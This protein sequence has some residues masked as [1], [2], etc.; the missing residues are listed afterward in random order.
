VDT[1]EDRGET[2]RLREDLVK[3]EE[4]GVILNSQ[5]RSRMKERTKQEDG[6]IN[7][8]TTMVGEQLQIKYHH[9]QDLITEDMV[10]VEVAKAEVVTEEVEV[11]TKVDPEPA[12]NVAKQVTLPVSAQTNP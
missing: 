3:E 4:A 2:R 11:E 1:V 5:A 7:L 9:Q 6:V 12:S 8:L 10:E